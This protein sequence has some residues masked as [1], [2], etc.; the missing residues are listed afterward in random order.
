M[1]PLRVV[2][3]CRL[4]PLVHLGGPSA[5]PHEPLV[6]LTPGSVEGGEHGLQIPG[7]A[8]GRVRN[9]GGQHGHVLYAEARPGAVVWGARVGGIADKADPA[10][11]KGREG[12]FSKVKE[13]PLDGFIISIRHVYHFD[14][15]LL[16][17]LFSFPHAFYPK[18]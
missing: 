2:S 8:N 11:V 5:A 14:Q 9:Q 18:N 1:D 15:V 4:T 13:T 12:V 6:P 7:V 16:V 17:F 10:V 3:Q